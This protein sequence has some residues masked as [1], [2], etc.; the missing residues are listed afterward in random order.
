MSWTRRALGHLALVFVLASAATV[1]VTGADV[2]ARRDSPLETSDANPNAPGDVS[3]RLNREERATL[4][5]V[6]TALIHDEFLSSYGKN[7]AL[8]LE[9]GK[10][11]LRGS[12][13]TY[14][15]RSEVELKAKE[16]AGRYAI[17]NELAVMAE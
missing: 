7:V 12:V 10:L 2:G 13:P 5:R 16:A 3:F 8:D 9:K 1:A 14:Y 17:V 4:K 11:I 15:E 6:R